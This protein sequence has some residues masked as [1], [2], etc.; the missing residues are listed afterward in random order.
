MISISCPAL[1]ADVPR[2][3]PKTTSWSSTVEVIVYSP[4]AK[5]VNSYFPLEFVFTIVTTSDW[6]F[7]ALTG[8]I[9]NASSSTPLNV[10]SLSISQNN[11]P[12]M[13]VGSISMSILNVEL[14]LGTLIAASSEIF[15]FSKSSAVVPV[16]ILLLTF[17][18]FS[19]SEILSP[20]DTIRVMLPA[21]DKTE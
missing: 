6:I 16:K 5:P 2:Y 21:T 3:V 11:L 8:V 17:L 9:A 12:V 19:S 18:I 10:P 4:G 7:V 14:T 15:T 1:V 20:N 13:L